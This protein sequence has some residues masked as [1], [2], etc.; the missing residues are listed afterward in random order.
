M[1]IINF[2]LLFFRNQKTMQAI[3]IIFL[4]LEKMIKFV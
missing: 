1:F 3:L 4:K 2:H